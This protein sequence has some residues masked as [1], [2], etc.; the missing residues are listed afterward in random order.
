[1]RK[2]DPIADGGWPPLVFHHQGWEVPRYG[3]ITLRESAKILGGP[4]IFLNNTREPLRLKGITDSK[5]DDWYDPEP[6]QKIKGDIP[7]DENFRAGFWLHAL[8]RFFVL[9]QWFARNP[10]HSFVHAELDVRLF[11]PGPLFDRLDAYAQGVFLPRASIHQAGANWLYCNSAGALD[12]LEKYLANSVSKG[13]EMQLLARFLDQDDDLHS[14]PTHASFEQH[15]RQGAPGFQAL[16]KIQ[17]GGVVDVQPLGTWLF[18]QDRRN[19][20]KQPI[21][22]HFYFE[23]IGTPALDELRFRYSWTNKALLVRH[24]S[25]K[26]EWPVF[27]LHVHSK[28]MNRAFSPVGLAFY[29]WLANRKFDSIIIFQNVFRFGLSRLKILTDRFYLQLGLERLWKRPN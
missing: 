16:E 6:F 24:V 13:F 2:S 4:I 26:E 29:A 15:G 11:A 20:P 3:L 8:E 14:V 19:S 5:L 10:H 25:S 18:G 7:M 28:V 22:N 21:F 9:N 27:A 23:E 12:R 17:I 1:M